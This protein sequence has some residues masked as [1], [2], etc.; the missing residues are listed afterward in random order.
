MFFGFGGPRIKEV[1]VEQVQALMAEKG[2]EILLLDVRTPDEFAQARVAGSKL[3]PLGELPK[4]LHEITA[5]KEKDV[6]VICR[7]G[8]RSASATAM[9]DQAGFQRAHN[10]VGGVSAWHRQGLPLA[11]QG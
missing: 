9:L 5:Y 1:E 8:N 7:S 4:R 2:K 10:V 6:M 11:F 3:I